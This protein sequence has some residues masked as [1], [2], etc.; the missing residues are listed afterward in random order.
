MNDNFDREPLPVFP[1]GHELQAIVLF[2]DVLT[3]E[4]KQRFKIFANRPDLVP[5]NQHSGDSETRIFRSQGDFNTAQ[6]GASRTFP[7]F[8]SFSTPRN[9]TRLLFS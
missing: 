8:R 5:V 4:P 7:A 2:D 1:E 9:K 3:A 6:K